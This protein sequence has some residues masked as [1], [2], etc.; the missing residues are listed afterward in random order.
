MAAD[1]ALLQFLSAPD[2]LLQLRIHQ[3]LLEGC[4]LGLLLFILLGGKLLVRQQLDC[5]PVL[6]GQQVLLNQGAKHILP[7]R[8]AALH[9]QMVTCFLCTGGKLYT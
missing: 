8:N 3:L 5:D 6:V 4:Q 7:R 1:L 2:D 9:K